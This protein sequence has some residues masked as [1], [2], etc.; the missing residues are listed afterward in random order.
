LS[1]LDNGRHTLFQQHVDQSTVDTITMTT[2]DA[3]LESKGCPTI[4]LLKVDVEGAELSVV[5]GM[6][7]LLE[8]NHELQMIIEFNP[9]L[10][11]NAS[12]DLEKFL[13]QPQQWGFEAFV[14]D[15]TTG[16]EP[17]ASID[18]PSLVNRLLAAEGSINMHYARG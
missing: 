2:V 14:I 5:R 6:T 15:E 12:V 16:V 18:I 11:R 3:F 13:L 9:M 4:G 7:K 8:K 10:L 1:S 17:L